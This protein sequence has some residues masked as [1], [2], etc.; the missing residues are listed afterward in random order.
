MKD[1]VDKAKRDLPADLPAD[2][3]VSEFDISEIPIMTVNVSGDFS[4]DKL[5]EYAET[6][7]DQIEEMREITRLDMI[8]TLEKEVQIDVDK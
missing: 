8:G 4:L 2:P 7:K 6:L 1:A 5:K 3:T